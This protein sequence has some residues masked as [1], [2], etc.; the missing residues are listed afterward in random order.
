MGKLSRM[1]FGTAMNEDVEELKENY[2]QL[3]FIASS[4]NKAINLNYKQI[5]R[6]NQHVDDLAVYSK[7]IRTSITTVASNGKSMCDVIVVNQTLP[8]LKNTI[9]SLLH[10][11]NVIIQ[12][13]VDAAREKVT[14]YLFP[15]KD[16]LRTLAL[17]VKD[18]DLKPLFDTRGIHH[19]YPLLESVLTSDAVVIHVPFQS[20]DKFEVYKIESF[21]FTVN[22][23]IM[24]LD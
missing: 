15:V 21:L 8:A 17:G 24:T 16:F 23:T 12:N 18:Y 2:N 5:A 9:N 22:G 20:A 1:L 13:M 7:Q 4:N 19:Y 3:A 11:N 10:A 6:L 14:S